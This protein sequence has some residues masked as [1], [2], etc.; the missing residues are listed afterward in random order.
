[1]PFAS[2]P[3]GALRRFVPWSF[4]MGLGKMATGTRRAS[5]VLSQFQPQAVL[6]TGGYVSAPVLMAAYM[7]RIPSLIFLPDVIPGWAI[8]L[9]SRLASKI[10]V[11]TAHSA[12]YLPYDKVV[13]TGF[14]VRPA[15]FQTTKAQAREQLNLDANTGTI[16]VLGGSQGA[17]SINQAIRDNLE[18]IL[19]THQLI[20]PAGTR[21]VPWL[22]NARQALP[23][24]LQQRYYLYDYLH[25]EYPLALAASDLAIAR[26]GASVLGE[27]PAA[28]L[29]SILVPYPHAGRH[30]EANAF[31]LQ[32][33]GAAKVL[34]DSQLDSLLPTLRAV[35]NDEDTLSQMSQQA[36][37]LARPEAPDRILDVIEDMIG[38]KG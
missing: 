35:L 22:R 1:V 38:V 12:Q 31:L 21:D 3:A 8:R 19:K 18:D 27:L 17:R 6:A 9:L 30:Q 32:R 23:N 7:R 11:T 24:N 15:F 20:H 13:E 29:P 34:P 2:I 14:P 33:T 25:E 26:A 4:V 10:A 5:A 36:K 16:I 28:G 37:N